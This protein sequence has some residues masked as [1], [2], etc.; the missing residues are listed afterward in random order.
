M[1]E[2]DIV[3]PNT[4]VPPPTDLIPVPNNPIVLDR[5]TDALS[6][7]DK[8]EASANLIYEN[9]R[10]LEVKDADSFAQAGQLIAQIKRNTAESEACM[11]PFKLKVRNVL[12]F[13]QQR[14]NRNKNRGTEA[15]GILSAKM[16]DYSRKEREATAAEN[17]ALN[18]KGAP[19]VQV[20]PN[21]PKVDGVRTTT[22]YPVEVVD[23]S[24]FLNAFLKGDKARRIFLG[25]FIALDE[26]ALARYAK[27]LK[28]PKQFM[29]EIPG[30][31]CEAKEAFGGKA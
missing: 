16:G 9:A 10:T 28:D 13:I 27:E 1:E 4:A 6:G 7:M 31:K 15:H 12:D 8:L 24:K 11:Q 20:E 29:A 19:P 23:R 18:K 21:L 25:K 26:S 3:V 2:Q 17:K 14:F 5:F 22:N 30:V